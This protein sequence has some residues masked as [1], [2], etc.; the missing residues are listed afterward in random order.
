MNAPVGMR[1]LR[2]TA[3]ASVAAIMA[4]GVW[5]A[6]D[7]IS[8]EPVRRVIFAGDARKLPRAELE[9]FAESIRGLPASGESL[10]AIRDAA[11]R[12]PWVREATVRRRFPDAV[13]I[14]FEAH[15]A[16]GRWSDDALL[17]VKGEIFSADADGW[18]PQF[19]GNAAAAPAIAREYPGIAQ[20]LAPVGKVA[21]VRLS[22]RGAWEVVLDSGLVVALGR[23]DIHA[24]LARFVA[25]WPQLPG[26][27]RKSPR[28]DL[29]Y[30]TGFALRV[31]PQ[32]AAAPRG[33]ARG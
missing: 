32:R 9:A 4:Y 20:A 17:S 1:V 2:A 12:L 14:A 30:G 28:A 29:R 22:P 33:K 15:E 6:F 16:L 23:G 25:A 8:H 11:R 7:T 3:A 18:L 21:E 13:E 31:E 19:S 10:A 5:Y 26:E 24:R 27:A